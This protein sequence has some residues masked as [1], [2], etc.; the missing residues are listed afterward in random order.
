MILCLRRQPRL[1]PLTVHSVRIIRFGGLGDVI[2]TTG[3]LQSVHSVFP[4]ADISYI[5]D[6][7][8]ASIF[9]HAPFPVKI[10]T[11][12]PFPK[13]RSAREWFRVMSRLRKRVVDVDIVL[14]SDVESVVAARFLRNQ[15][16]LGLEANRR[17]YGRIFDRYIEVY[18]E[19]FCREMEITSQN[20]LTELFHECAN[21]AFGRSMPRFKPR[22]WLRHEEFEAGQRY[23]SKGCEVPLV[24][25]L[26]CG[27]EPLKMWP[28]S[29]YGEL[30]QL[31]TERLGWIVVVLGG[32]AEAL[33]RGHFER[34]SRIHFLAGKLS[35]RE[36]FA[37][38]AAANVVVGNDTGM[39]HA[40]VAL[41]RPTIALFG[42]SHPASWGYAGPLNHILRSNRLC[43]PCYAT[44]CALRS[45]GGI[46]NLDAKSAVCLEDITVSQVFQSVEM[47]ANANAN[48]Q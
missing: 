3:L 10:E 41:E 9:E 45:Q 22:L 27:S 46:M 7:A 43:M 40:A 4:E 26:P 12:T 16:V 20:H 25:L 5:T 21:F 36:S 17:G 23:R 47:L 31:I 8:I 30:A 33:Q 32:K 24:G 11:V 29:R 35:L 48:R 13:I 1:P 34:G 44:A 14:Q 15:F 2:A 19:A 37:V 39:M 42:P 28:Y 18:G 38:I 6:A